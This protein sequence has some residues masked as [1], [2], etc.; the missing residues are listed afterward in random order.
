MNITEQK[1]LILSQI[2][3]KKEQIENLKRSAD[4]NNAMQLAIKLVLNGSYGAFLNK[5]FVCF[6]D[7]VGSSITSHGRELTKTM[8]DVNEKYWYEEFHNDIK[9]QRSV[10]LHS[11]VLSYIEE[12]KLNIRDILKND[13]NYDGLYTKEYDDIVAELN[14]DFEKLDL[15]KIRKLDDR[16]L[17]WETGEEVKD[18]TWDDIYTKTGAAVRAEPVSIYADTDSIDKNTIIRTDK[19]IYSVE[20]L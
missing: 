12:N 15:G 9:T 4:I 2:K 5:H 13:K 20:K 7:A 11:K 16:Y 19:G 18:P 1:E 14:I 10:Y 6:C 3:Q 8:N 17:N